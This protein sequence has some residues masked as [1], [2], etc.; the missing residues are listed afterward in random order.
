MEPE[1]RG[2]PAAAAFLVGL[3]R[4][5]PLAVILVLAV[6]VAILSDRGG[7]V[8]EV[9]QAAEV[10]LEV[11]PL[12]VYRPGVYT[13]V[14][15]G[16]TLESVCRRLARDEWPRWR[17][18]LAARLDPRRLRPGTA[19]EGACSPGGALEE[20]RVT[21]DPLHE[22]RLVREDGGIRCEQHERPL[23]AEVMTLEGTI[24]SSLF[25]AV[26]DAGADP[27]LAVRVAEIFQWDIDF[28]RDLRRGDQ[29]VVL[30][31]AERVDG[32][33]YRWGTI[34]AARFVN[35]QRTLD[36]FV[37]PD[38]E[39]RLGYYDGQGNPLRKQFLRSPLRFSRVTS[40]FTM[41]RYHPVLHRTMPHYG[42][43]YGAPVGTPVMATAD[44]VVTLAGTNGGAGRM[45]TLR[46]PNGYETSYLHLSRYGPGVR[47]GARVE[48]GQVVGYVG[49]S[50]LSTGPHLDYRVKMNGR[51]VNPLTLAS[52]PA[53]PLDDTRQSRFVS[54]AEAVVALLEGR[55]PPPG[56]RG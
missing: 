32:E 27:D 19:F 52:P 9:G 33:F 50:G 31:S 17:D 14:S 55:E 8:S 48:Q 20:L 38:D 18:S 35:G 53:K 45:V 16:D 29:F 13:E 41:R 7:L 49:S 25:A 44:G 6:A 26:E 37:Y 10:R 54:H 36:A 21:L 39:G 5:R 34:Y 42:V 30:A 51:W 28:L 43:D 56:A 12:P 40:R 23:E 3:A 22:L 15:R 11:E 47:G 24:Q 1:V 4:P 2:R 46:H